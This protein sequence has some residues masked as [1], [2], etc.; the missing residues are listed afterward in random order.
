[1]IKLYVYTIWILG[2][3]LFVCLMPL[4]LL[5]DFLLI[6]LYWYRY[7]K[8]LS[9]LTVWKVDLQR[10]IS[11]HVAFYTRMCGLLRMYDEKKKAL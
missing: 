6:P 4:T 8:P 2:H 7:R 3:A 5:G 10:A 1:M 11:A 9:I